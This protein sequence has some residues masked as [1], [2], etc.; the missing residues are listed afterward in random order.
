M[1][2]E[3]DL[4]NITN[5]PFTEEKA[6]EMAHQLDAIF[7]GSK[8]PIKGTDL[9]P[10][11]VE[12]CF[13]TESIDTAQFAKLDYALSKVPVDVFIKRSGTGLSIRIY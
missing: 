5:M 3:P 8:K 6:I 2:M 9:T 12:I 13:T 1:A 10:P 7:P 11:K 4:I